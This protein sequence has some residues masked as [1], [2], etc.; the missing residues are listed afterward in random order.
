MA[1]A[2]AKGNGAQHSL[3]DRGSLYESEDFWGAAGVVA[4]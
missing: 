1:A 2:A 4:Y 3:R